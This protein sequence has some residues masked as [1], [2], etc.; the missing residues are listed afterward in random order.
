ML[1]KTVIYCIKNETDDRHDVQDWCE[2]WKTPI[3]L[4]NKSEYRNSEYSENKSMNV[5][6]LLVF[7]GCVVSLMGLY[8]LYQNQLV[9]N[10]HAISN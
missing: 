3:L 9:L 10:T 2:N 6:A 1:N 4:L 5:L 7:Q 8:I